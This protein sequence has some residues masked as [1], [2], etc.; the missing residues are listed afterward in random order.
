MTDKLYNSLYLKD[1][2]IPEKF[3]FTIPIQQREYLCDGVVR[4]WDGLLQEVLSPLCEMVDGTAQQKLIGS[5][6]LLTG[7]GNA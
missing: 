2:A 5:Y 4:N 1:N 3:R 7:N 6:P